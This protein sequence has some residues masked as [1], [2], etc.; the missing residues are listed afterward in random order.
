M[1]KTLQIHKSSLQKGSA[2]RQGRLKNELQKL[3]QIRMKK[4]TNYNRHYNKLP[5]RMSLQGR[6]K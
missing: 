2:E 4:E 3:Q 6:G 1:V 5:Q